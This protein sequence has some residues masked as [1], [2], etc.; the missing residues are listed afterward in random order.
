MAD[1]YY[2]GIPTNRQNTSKTKF[3]DADLVR[4]PSLEGLYDAAEQ[5]RL[6]KENF[7]RNSRADEG[8][9]S[10]DDLLEAA[11]STL[12]NTAQ[13][14]GR[15]NLAE[16]SAKGQ[17]P[18]SAEAMAPRPTTT[19]RDVADQTL[20]ALSFLPGPV[21][22]GARMGS[23]ALGAYDMATEGPDLGNIAQVGF[24]LMEAVPAI[25]ALAKA[26][27]GP[28]LPMPGSNVGRPV[29]VETPDLPYRFN[30]SM[31]DHMT[32]ME[33]MPF[34]RPQSPLPKGTPNLEFQ[35]NL[36]RPGP[37]GPGSPSVPSG[38]VFNPLDELREAA[39]MPSAAAARKY[40]PVKR[41][42]PKGPKVREFSE[43]EEKGIAELDDLLTRTYGEDRPA[44]LYPGMGGT[45]KEPVKPT[46]KYLG[47][48]EI[49]DLGNT[50]SLYNI[51]GGDLNGGTVTADTLKKMGI[52]VPSIRAMAQEVMPAERMSALDAIAAGDTRDVLFGG[53]GH[54]KGSSGKFVRPSERGPVRVTPGYRNRQGKK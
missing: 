36:T 48:Q 13:S 6:E 1:F 44:N 5:A 3:T 18:A 15:L 41:G 28:K 9:Q 54:G 30:G 21:G 33:P 19:Y 20:G 17:G 45:Y 10:L 51:Q 35:G 38:P 14:A 4:R 11:R 16:Q 52:E 32:P 8:R 50:I 34:N 37:K 23:G 40:D 43:G 24:G 46:A 26:P 12:A 22:A 42:M 2:P 49:D 47:E 31:P 7:E 29:R 39:G 27:A 25:R 53:A